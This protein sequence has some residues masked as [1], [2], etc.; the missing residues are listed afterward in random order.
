M[1][2][3]AVNGHSTP[4][5]SQTV[6][7][8]V[9]TQSASRKLDDKSVRNAAPPLSGNRIIYDTRL[10]GFGMRITV[11]G[12]RSFVF[13]YS[14]KGRERRITLGQFPAWSVLA[15]RKQVEHLRRQVDLGCDPL[16]ERVNDRE[17]PTVQKLFERYVAEH[18]PTKSPRCAVDDRIMWRKDILPAFGP[19]KVAELG[20]QDCDALHRS[21]SRTRPI[22][23]N[24]VNEV[25]RKAL[26]LAVR[27][28][29]ID[30]NPASGVRPNPEQK[31][32]RYLSREEISRLIE[33]LDNHPERASADAILFMLLT[34]CRKGE[35]LNARWDHLDLA[36]RIWTKPSSETKQRREHRVPYSSV[37]AGIL[38]Q[39]WAEADGAYIFPGSFGAPLREVRKTWQSACC[40]AQLEN[41]RVHDLRHTFA[42]LVAS[43][44]QS[45][46]IVGELLGHSTAQTTKRYAHLY[47]DSLR[48]AAEGVAICLGLGSG[49]IDQSQKMTV[50][51]M[52]MAD[53]KVCAHRS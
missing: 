2:N 49:L 52:Q 19:R 26:N 45:L 29:W 48:S 25:L 53:M 27:W 21:I 43:S 6:A 9:R 4:I 14:G 44:G 22:R 39:R 23:A 47:D 3:D 1:P 17:A 12:A 30:R 5:T 18:L 38:E 40:T 15:A 37:V 24:R 35:A 10:S 51:A 32:N 41:V 46:L 28:D 31:R 20:P 13:N 7:D 36:R 11:A 16:E 33:A 8:T 42:S 50:A 34:G